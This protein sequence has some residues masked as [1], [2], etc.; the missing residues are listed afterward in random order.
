[1]PSS[2]R[3]ARA[4]P[5]L[6]KRLNERTV[7]EAIRAGAPISRAEISRR[8]GI[9]KPTVSLALQSLLDAGLVREAAEHP[10]GPRYGAVF[11]EPVPDAALVLGL[12]LGA[13]FLRGAICDLKGVVRARQDVELRGARGAQALDVFTGLR[14]SLIEATGLPAD[15]V[16]SAVVGV[17]GAIPPD[18]RVR[19]AAEWLEG[20]DIAAD[21]EPRLGIQVVVEN[22]VN[23]AALGERWLGVG[24]G[25][26]DFAFLTVGTGVG[27]GLVL[28]GE[29]H[30]GHAGSAG[31]VHFLAAGV[32]TDID[33]TAGAVSRVAAAYAAADGVATSLRRPFEAP[34]VFSAARGG[35][36]I[37]RKVVGEVAWRIAR[38]AVMV[39]AVSDV[40]LI[41]LGGGVGSNGDLL[42]EPIR[43]LLAKWMEFPPRVEVSSL[44]E[45]AVLSGALFV[46]L[47]AALDHVFES[48]RPLG[49]TA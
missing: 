14:D 13:R 39:A 46:G 23:L 25:V 7:L 16:H 32:E 43:S 36:E 6:L 22:D 19:L 17:P 49:A 34:A 10:E 30:R 1:M 26:D 9:S 33:P 29:L 21:L 12:D 35:D 37:A 15:L 28:R 45:A 8:A 11:F 44:G 38:Y 27:A 20:M 24:R 18:G 47:R 40:E 3:H 42:L 5:P 2:P 41:V 31:E 48:R 4:V